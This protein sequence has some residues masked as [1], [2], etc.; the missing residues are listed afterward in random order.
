MT[1]TVTTAAEAVAKGVK[2]LE[3]G[4]SPSS[5]IGSMLMEGYGKGCSDGCPSVSN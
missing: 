3:S 1:V 5:S 2:G 4:K